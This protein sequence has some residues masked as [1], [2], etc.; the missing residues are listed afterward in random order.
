MSV[1]GELV[2]FCLENCKAGVDTGQVEQLRP[3]FCVQF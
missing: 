1:Q 3:E 2:M